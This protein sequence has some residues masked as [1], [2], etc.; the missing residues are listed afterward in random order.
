MDGSPRRPSTNT[1]IHSSILPSIQF[2]MPQSHG[3]MQRRQ[4]A[5]QSGTMFTDLQSIA[6]SIRL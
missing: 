5:R 1:P 6:A 4:D 2:D 3:N